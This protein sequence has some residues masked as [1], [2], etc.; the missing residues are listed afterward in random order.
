MIDLELQ[1]HMTQKPSPS[2]AISGNHV[3]SLSY[4]CRPKAKMVWTHRVL[5]AVLRLSSR[6]ICL[7]VAEV[8]RPRVRMATP[9]ANREATRV[10]PKRASRR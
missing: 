3:V 7:V 9:R 5:V 1:V 8:P 4:D 2:R 6:S 10:R